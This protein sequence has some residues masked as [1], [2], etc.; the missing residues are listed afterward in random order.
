MR[1]GLLDLEWKTPNLSSIL[2]LLASPLFCGGCSYFSPFGC[3]VGPFCFNSF[4]S[5]WF[6]FFIA[7]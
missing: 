6:L 2:E 5:F 7:L 3:E 4:G 1:V